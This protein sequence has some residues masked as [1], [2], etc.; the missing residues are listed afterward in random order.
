MRPPA[1]ATRRQLNLW[2][3]LLATGPKRKFTPN[4]ME[5]IHAETWKVECSHNKNWIGVF[6]KPF[7]G[8]IKVWLTPIRQKEAL[9]LIKMSSFNV[10]C[11]KTNEDSLNVLDVCMHGRGTSSC[12]HTNHTNVKFGDKCIPLKL[13]EFFILKALFQAVSMDIRQLVCHNWLEKNRGRGCWNNIRQRRVSNLK[14]P[15]YLKKQVHG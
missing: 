10:I 15:S 3:K 13:G 4:A 5:P 2:H 7:H 11:W 9:Q 14:N 6:L 8:F 1:A 12:H